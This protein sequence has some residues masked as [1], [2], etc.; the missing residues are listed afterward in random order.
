MM[1]R[2]HGQPAS[3]TTLGKEFLNVSYRFKSQ[4]EKI[5]KIEFLGKMNG[6]VGNYNAHLSAY[7]DIDWAK[8][9]KGFIESLGLQQNICTIQIEPHDYIVNLSHAMHAVNSI[10]LDFATDVWGYISI[11][12]FSQKTNPNEVGSSTMPHKVNPIDFENAEGN[13][14]ISNSWL[15]FFAT[16]LPISRWQ[17]DLTDSTVLRNIG[18]SFAHS[19][20]AY[21]SLLAGMNKIVA[22]KEELLK[23]LDNNYGLLAEPVQTVMRTYGINDA[24]EQLKSFTRNK[25]ID[26]ETM[27]AFIKQLQ[28]PQEKKD[29]LLKTTPANYIGDAIKITSEE[30]LKIEEWLKNYE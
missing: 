7:S 10:L 18:C 5:Q 23:D 28:I 1:A 26:K 16:R 22:K 29:E 2:T 24:Y 4:I 8:F 3:P 6:A 9:S 17:R 30:T 13:L 20:I 15:H 12:Y 11:G 14:A 21:K 27:L 25:N 19:L